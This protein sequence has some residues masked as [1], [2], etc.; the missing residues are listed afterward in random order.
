MWTPSNFGIWSS[1]MTNAIPALKPIK[2]G[3]EM[4]LATKPNRRSAASRRMAPTRRVRVA[5][6]FVNEVG[7]P[8]TATRLSAVAARMA[9]VVVVLTLSGRDVPTIA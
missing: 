7:S 1:T 9:S 5:D 6:A 8:A 3:S 4:K 2:T